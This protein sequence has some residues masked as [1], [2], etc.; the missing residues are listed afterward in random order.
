MPKSRIPA[1]MT[2]LTLLI[3]GGSCFGTASGQTAEEQARIGRLQAARTPCPAQPVT[4]EER[5]A[6]SQRAMAREIGKQDGYCW[7]VPDQT[8]QSL[9]YRCAPRTLK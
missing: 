2:I 3:L 4:Q 6:C 5:M 9:A 7:S 1:L 8:T